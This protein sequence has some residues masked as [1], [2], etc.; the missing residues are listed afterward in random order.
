MRSE[1]PLWRKLGRD[2]R[3]MV[4]EVA[5]LEPEQAAKMAQETMLV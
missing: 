1:Y 3:L 5:T 2:T 4:A